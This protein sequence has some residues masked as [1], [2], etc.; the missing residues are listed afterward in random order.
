MHGHL[1]KLVDH[2]RWADA[3]ALRSLREWDSGAGKPTGESAPGHSSLR[4]R[5][6]ALYAHV[7]GAEA[8]WLSRLAG[9]AQDV[10]VW[11]DL[12]LDEAAALAQRNA[13]ELDRFIAALG[14]DDAAREV[15]YRNSAGQAFRSTV[16]DILLQVTLHGTYHRGQIAMLVRDGGA[17]PAP[18]DYIA[19]VRGAPAART[20]PLA[21]PAPR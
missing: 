21:T 12:T 6:V 13:D 5:A 2:L 17:A 18:T 15:D 3:A 4:Q 7:V 20:T 9:R 16:E 8:V 14:P 19:F 1:R 10:A 11:P